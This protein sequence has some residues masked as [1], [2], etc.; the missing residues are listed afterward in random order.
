MAPASVCAKERNIPLG[1]QGIL[2]D[3]ALLP[4]SRSNVSPSP[5]TQSMDARRASW[6]MFRTGRRKFGRR[7]WPLVPLGSGQGTRLARQE[8]VRARRHRGGT[9]VAAVGIALD[10][11]MTIASMDQWGIQV[12]FRRGRGGLGASA[13]IGD[14]AAKASPSG[15]LRGWDSATASKRVAPRRR[16]AASGPRRR[17]ILR[18]AHQG[19][20]TSR[21]PAPSAT[22]EG[23][24]PSRITPEDQKSGRGKRRPA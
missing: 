11:L 1:P 6:V 5:R 13:R 4:G 24:R 16:W 23:V 22:C 12:G 2:T 10:G 14:H 17:E 8:T 18:E 20:C 3:F 19:A 15:T 21:V 9:T 7:R